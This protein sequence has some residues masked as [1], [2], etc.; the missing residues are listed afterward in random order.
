M[1]ELLRQHVAKRID[2]TDGEWKEFLALFK[3]IRLKK[4][5]FLTRHGEVN[6]T[7]AYIVSGCL[8]TFYT[9]A[10]S[11]EHTIQIGFEDWW[12]GDLLAYV[13]ATPAHYSVEALEDT[14]LLLLRR[15]D[16]EEF[17][18]RNLKFEKYF[19]ILLQSAYVASQL[20]MINTMSKSAEERYIELIKKHPQMELR[21]AQHH[22]AS[23]LGITPE[24]LSRIKRSIIEK[25]RLDRARRSI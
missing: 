25:T 1:S 15:D 10:K 19:R 6:D 8:R 23:Y 14:E 13:T 4:R 11:H 5:D 7:N 2:I 16:Q 21:I 3:P 18:A 12:A 9:D 22:I 20:R 24:A 17:Y